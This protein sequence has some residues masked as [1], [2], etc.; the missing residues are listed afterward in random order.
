[1][2]EEKEERLAQTSSRPEDRTEQLKLKAEIQD[3]EVHRNDLRAKIDFYR[4]KCTELENEEIVEKYKSLRMQMEKIRSIQ[5]DKRE[6]AET[7]KT[8]VQNK[9]KELENLRV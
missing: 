9:T 7:I 4:K 3:L 2:I 5:R 1:M 6:Q 8:E